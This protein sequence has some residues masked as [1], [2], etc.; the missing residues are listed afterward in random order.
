MFSIFA[1]LSPSGLGSEHPIFILWFPFLS[2]RTDVTPSAFSS[3]PVERDSCFVPLP[4][5]A[6]RLLF[7]LLKTTSPPAF[8]TFSATGSKSDPS[9]EILSKKSSGILI[10]T[11]ANTAHHL[12]CQNLCIHTSTFYVLYRGNIKTLSITLNKVFCRNLN[13]WNSTKSKEI[14]SFRKCS[15]V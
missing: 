10:S 3:S 4:I 15:Q 6:D 8:S 5:T 2:N 1:L 9:F 12:L 13:S 14:R 11:F 7:V